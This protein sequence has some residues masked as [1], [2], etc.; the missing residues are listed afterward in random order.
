MR[1]NSTDGYIFSTVRGTSRADLYASSADFLL[2]SAEDL[3]SFRAERESLSSTA[4]ADAV[5]PRR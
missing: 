4:G 3:R 2:L 1:H 5:S